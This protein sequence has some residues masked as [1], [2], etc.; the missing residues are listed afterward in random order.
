M[1]FQCT[2]VVKAGERKTYDAFFKT[3]DKDGDGMV[4]GGDIMKIFLTSKLPKDTL[5]H[6]WNLVDVDD[7]GAINSEQ[8]ALAM[9][10][11]AQT[12]KGKVI[13]C[14]L[15]FMAV[16]CRAFL[17]AEQPICTSRF[18]LQP[19]SMRHIQKMTFTDHETALLYFNE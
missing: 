3:A 2:G 13:N 10:F 17:Q 16:S 8:F 9:H 12:V 14:K 19:V 11:I 18:P 4:A 5:A 7:V 1:L 6:I 15:P